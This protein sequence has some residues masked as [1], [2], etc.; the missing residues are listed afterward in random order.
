MTYCDT[1]GKIKYATR[2]DADAAVRGFA[3]RGGI[4]RLTAYH[5]RC[6][7]F[8]IGRVRPALGSRKGRVRP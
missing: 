3:N 5:C 4:G 7:G 1:S 6:G 8:H 2:T